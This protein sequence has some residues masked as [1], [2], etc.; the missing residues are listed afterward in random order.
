MR[1]PVGADPVPSAVRMLRCGRR[2]AILALVL[3]MATGAA[4]A[5]APVRFPPE[6]ARL[7]ELIQLPKAGRGGVEKSGGLG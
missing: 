7:N 2:G 5:Q 1:D 4:L 3:A 6:A